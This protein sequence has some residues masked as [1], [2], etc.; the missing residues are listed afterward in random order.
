LEEYPVGGPPADGTA[1][2]P[3]PYQP[4][5]GLPAASGASPYRRPD[6]RRIAVDPLTGERVR[7]GKPSGRTGSGRARRYRNVALVLGLLVAT[8]AGATGRLLVSDL[9]PATGPTSTALQTDSA[10]LSP[11]PTSSP[12]ETP[13]PSPTPTETIPVVTGST[14]QV[15]FHDMML[16]S[17]ASKGLARTFAFTSDGQGSVSGHVVAAAPLDN[18]SLCVVVNDNPPAC[19][20]GATPGFSLATPPGDHST[21][22]VTVIATKSLS[23]PIVD[24]AFSWPSIAP[25]IT[26]TH[27]RFQGLPNPDTLRGITVDFMPRNSGTA[28]LAARWPPTTAAK[29]G[30]E[31]LDI[32][33]TPGTRLE[34]KYW[35]GSA[36]SPDYTLAVDAKRPYEFILRNSAKDSGR[37]DLT[38]TLTFP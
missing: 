9:N 13:T 21:W 22:V 15:V 17:S 4:A 24:L 23:T 14:A 10:A 34:T 19:A 36:I 31:V 11:S 16:D 35:N 8:M 20:S 5:P 29:A 33:K 32:T 25:S 2:E 7:K 1:G 30:L 18:I 3:A 27:G 26:L 37:P 28:T 6:S 12:T 38:A